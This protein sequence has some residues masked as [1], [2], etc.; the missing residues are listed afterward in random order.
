MLLVSVAVLC[1]ACSA[2]E[3]IANENISEGVSKETTDS[4]EEVIE[5]I[6]I[7]DSKDADQPTNESVETSVAENKRPDS[8]IYRPELVDISV[9]INMDDLVLDDLE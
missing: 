5:E 2:Q 1:F 3:P 7:P 8:S 9:Y 4:A 6:V